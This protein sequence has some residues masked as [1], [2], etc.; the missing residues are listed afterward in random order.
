MAGND[1]QAKKAI[2]FVADGTEEMEATITIDVL[3]RAGIQVLVLAVEATIGEPVTCSR[4]V[5]I[6]PD[7][8]L[9]DDSA[10]IGAFDA[11][12]V[13]G[14]AQGAAT[15]SQN[16][17]VKSIL[18]DFHAQKKIVAAICA[19]SLAIKTAG[20]Q[21]KVPQPLRLTSHPSV[22]DQLENDFVYK[23]DRVV[24]DANLVTSRGPGTAFEFALSLVSLLA[25]EDKAREV[26]GPMMLNFEI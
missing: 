18:A 4:N 21:S 19:G 22:K 13:P 6:V 17:Q 15:L 14:G 16:D 12:I 25:G 3:R 23:E 11:V 9:G 10:K 24:V 2:V 26:A 7:A 8:Y 5:K 1:R 20:I